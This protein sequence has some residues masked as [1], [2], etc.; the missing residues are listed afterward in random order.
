LHGIAEMERLAKEHGFPEA[1]Y[2]INRVSQD[3]LIRPMGI[4]QLIDYVGVDVFQCILSVMNRFIEGEDLH[5]DLV[6]RILAD[7]RAGP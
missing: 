6:D 3:W 7:R 4:F 1:V 5:S 2:M